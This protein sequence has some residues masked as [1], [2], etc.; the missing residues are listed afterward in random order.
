MKQEGFTIVELTI[1]VI[2]IAVLA[3]I[4]VISYRGI[5]KRAQTAAYTATADTAEKQIRLS[6]IQD[7]SIDT[8]Q[9]FV[10]NPS[11]SASVCFGTLADFPAREGFSEGECMQ[12]FANGTKVGSVFVDVDITNRIAGGD[13]SFKT[14][15]LPLVT[16]KVDQENEIRSRGIVAT[17]WGRASMVTLVWI[18]PDMSGCGRGF[19]ALGDVIALFRD[20]RDGRKTREEA[21]LPPEVTIEQINAALEAY[22]DMGDMCVL[23][24]GL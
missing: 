14:G 20:V 21:N 7:P 4:S 18:A 1:V 19:G 6:L 22:S 24:F 11:I 2:V 9:R 8:F 10:D 5:Q 23:Q 13:S 12:Q 3:T 15:A 17:I 16:L